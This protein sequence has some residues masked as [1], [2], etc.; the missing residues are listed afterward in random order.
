ME[1][2]RRGPRLDH[3]AKHAAVKRDRPA[4]L[5]TYL[6][7]KDAAPASQACIEQNNAQFRTLSC[8]AVVPSDMVGASKSHLIRLPR[9]RRLQLV[10]EHIHDPR[11]AYGSSRT[12]RNRSNSKERP[13][14]KRDLALD[15]HVQNLPS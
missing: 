13:T 12:L 3:S 5:S 8:F 4:D 2:K 1:V 15:P 7:L 10:Q 11:T 6:P 9:V 14:P